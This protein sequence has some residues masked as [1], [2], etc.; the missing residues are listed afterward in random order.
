MVK[1][2]EL[3]ACCEHASRSAAAWQ[4]AGALSANANPTTRFFQDGVEQS[5]SASMIVCELPLQAL[6]LREPADVCWAMIF[7]AL[8][9]WRFCRV[10]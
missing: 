8:P 6:H 2:A 1:S 4:L 10:C 7:W 9:C 3:V 5:S